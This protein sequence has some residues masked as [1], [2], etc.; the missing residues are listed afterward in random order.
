MTGGPINMAFRAFGF[1]TIPS[2][3]VAYLISSICQLQRAPR[4]ATGIPMRWYRKGKR[5]RYILASPDV[6]LLG[7]SHPKAIKDDI[8]TVDLQGP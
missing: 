4:R 3:A 5:A 1:Y 2:Y 7:P 8:L 6:T